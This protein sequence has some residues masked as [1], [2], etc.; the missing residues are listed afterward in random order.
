MFLADKRQMAAPPAAAYSGRFSALGAMRQQRQVAALPRLLASTCATLRGSVRQ[1]RGVAG[2]YQVLKL[3][4]GLRDLAPAVFE[5]DRA[6]EY[7][8]ARLRIDRVDAEVAQAFELKARAGRG[9]GQ[10][11]L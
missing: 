7:G 11:R 5:G 1:G 4:A 6:V 3:S 10:G 8:R 2:R 9:L